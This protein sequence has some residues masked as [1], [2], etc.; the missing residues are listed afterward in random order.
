MSP[1]KIKESSEE[2]V[3]FANM[4]FLSNSDKYPVFANQQLAYRPFAGL[5]CRNDPWGKEKQKIKRRME[6]EQEE[7]AT[8]TISQWPLASAADTNIGALAMAPVQCSSP[9]RVAKTCF[10]RGLLSQ[11]LHS[12]PL[13]I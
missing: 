1:W 4:G 13:K 5:V 3:I 11:F 12:G 7:E 2:S 10:T 9:C 6:E 8:R